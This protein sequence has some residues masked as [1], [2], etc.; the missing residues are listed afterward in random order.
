MFLKISNN[1]TINQNTFRRGCDDKFYIKV[2]GIYQTI[3]L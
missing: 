2:F 1:S 3:D